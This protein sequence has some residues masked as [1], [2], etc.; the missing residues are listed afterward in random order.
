MKKYVG[1]IGLA[2]RARKLACGTESVLDAIR[3]KK[4]VL[5]IVASDA[6]ADTKKK[7]GDKCAFYGGG[8][9][10]LPITKSELGSALGRNETAAAAF[11][12][13]SFVKAFEASLAREEI[14]LAGKE[15]SKEE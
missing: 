14:T 3:S 1:V 5:A 6:S 8:Y 9:V 7:L 12:D 15:I 11:L 2:F 13:A 10:V 4:S